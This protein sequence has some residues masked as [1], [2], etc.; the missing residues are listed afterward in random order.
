MFVFKIFLSFREQRDMPRAY[1]ISRNLR[2]CKPTQAVSP[3]LGLA[4]VGWDCRMVW[5]SFHFRTWREMTRES[6]GS[7]HF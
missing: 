2:R 4:G 1:S 7:F 3:L 6:L 5:I